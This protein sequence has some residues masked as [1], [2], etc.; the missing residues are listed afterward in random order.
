VLATY[1]IERGTLEQVGWMD[2]EDGA[3]IAVIDG[4]P[5][6]MPAHYYSYDVPVYCLGNGEQKYRD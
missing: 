6:P 1:L 5:R 3:V 2:P 4:P